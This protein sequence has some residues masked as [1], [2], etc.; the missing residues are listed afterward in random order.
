MSGSSDL[1]AVQHHFTE[2]LLMSKEDLEQ[3]EKDNVLSL[4]QLGEINGG[5]YAF[6]WSTFSGAC[7][8]VGKDEWSTL[9]TGCKFDI[10][11]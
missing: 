2:V 3:A 6:A 11:K 5:A 4:Q 8:G 7:G 10:L 1:F 9:S